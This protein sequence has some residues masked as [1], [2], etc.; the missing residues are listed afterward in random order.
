MLLMVAVKRCRFKHWFAASA[1]WEE[2]AYVVGQLPRVVE[3]A[4]PVSFCNNSI[5]FLLI[6]SYLADCPREALSQAL[7]VFL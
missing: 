2:I 6:E 4:S 7:G 3:R 5:A 1:T